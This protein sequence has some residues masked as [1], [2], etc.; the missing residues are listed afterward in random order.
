MIN[1][2]TSTNSTIACYTP[3][4]K[5]NRNKEKIAHYSETE[6]IVQNYVTKKKERINY[7]TSLVNNSNS[8]S[9]RVYR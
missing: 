3:N 6:G 9:N 7:N 2:S 5:G 1:S 4:T 8:I